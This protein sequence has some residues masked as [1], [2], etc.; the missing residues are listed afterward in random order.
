LISQNQKTINA[1]IKV[2][3]KVKIAIRKTSQ[4]IQKIMRKS[5][6]II[7]ISIGFI[8]CST[9]TVVSEMESIPNGWSKDEPILFTIPKLDSVKLYNLFLTVRNNNEYAYNNLFLITKL[10][11]PNGK[12][13]TDTLEYKM[14]NPDGTWLGKG[15][16]AIKESKL[17]CKESINFKEEGNYTLLVMHAMRNNGEV[18]GVT[19]L[20]GITDVGYSIEKINI[21]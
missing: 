21:E 10:N 8:A 14:A 11:F 9:D 13:V 5:F 15:V 2:V 1:E 18:E 19:N 3:I 20:Q 17:W 12:V 16:G 4:E 7:I 6:A